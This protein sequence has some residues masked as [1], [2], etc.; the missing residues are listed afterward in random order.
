MISPDD[1]QKL[2]E[3]DITQEPTSHLEDLE[4]IKITGNTAAERLENFLS[5]VKNPYCF[6]VGNTPVKIR[7]SHGEKTIESAL[8]RYFSSIKE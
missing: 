4:N 7:F 5:Q 1:L 2:S 6:K 8:F 3:K